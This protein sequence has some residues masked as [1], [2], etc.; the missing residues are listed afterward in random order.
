M[1]SVK[2]RDLSGSLNK[3]KVGTRRHGHSN[4]AS[5]NPQNSPVL[6][7]L[8]NQCMRCEGLSPIT[9]LLTRRIS[10]GISVVL[11]PQMLDSCL[12]SSYYTILLLSLYRPPNTRPLPAVTLVSPVAGTFF[13]TLLS[14]KLR[15][16][17]SIY[18]II[19]NSIIVKVVNFIIEIP[20]M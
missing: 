6:Y 16:F 8:G 1:S 7:R 12:N 19:F 10:A 2:V 5:F 11:T 3:N 17:K 14:I 18:I 20:R 4:M 13:K 15:Y 9:E